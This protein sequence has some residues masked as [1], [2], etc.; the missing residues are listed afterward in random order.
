MNK[1]I[2]YKKNAY[3]LHD[4]RLSLN[5]NGQMHGDYWVAIKQVEFILYSTFFS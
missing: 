4:A 2:K 1:K 5:T 3:K